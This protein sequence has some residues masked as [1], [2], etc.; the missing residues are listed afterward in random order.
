MNIYDTKLIYCSRCG[1]FIGE[2][3][4]G[5]IVTPPKCGKCVNPLPEGDDSI[6]YLPSKVKNN[7]GKN[8]KWLEIV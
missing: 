4:Y 5:E 3:D 8:V 2:I 7:A 1:K 6:S